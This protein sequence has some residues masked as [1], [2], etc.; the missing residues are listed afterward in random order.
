MRNFNRLAV[1]LLAAS[2]ASGTALA[3]EGDIGPVYIKGVAV[4]TQNAIGHRAGNLELTMSSPFT[5]PTGVS[6][7]TS[8]I[9]TLAANDPD[10]KLLALSTA[11]QL[12]R[13]PVLLHISDNATLNAFPGR[14]SLVAMTLSQ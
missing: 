9:T 4:I 2:L 13:S 1:C 11:A 8:Y 6:C 14:C 7:D 3:G 5:L 12:S 10:K